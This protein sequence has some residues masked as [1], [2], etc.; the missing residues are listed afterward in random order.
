MLEIQEKIFNFFFE[1]YLLS[2]VRCSPPIPLLAFG[3]WGNNPLGATSHHVFPRHHCFMKLNKALR[4]ISVNLRQ[5]EN[6]YEDSEC[7]ILFL[8]LDEEYHGQD[9]LV[10]SKTAA[11]TLLDKPEE[12]RKAFLANC[13]VSYSEEGECYGIT[14]PQTTKELGSFSF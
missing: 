7:P 1:H 12:E 6:K 2:C 3:E 8:T 9:Y 11:E 10:M 5:S 14:M 13:E 4:G